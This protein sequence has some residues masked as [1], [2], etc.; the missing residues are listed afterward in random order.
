[1]PA[2][3]ADALQKKQEGRRDRKR[4]VAAKKLLKKPVVLAAVA[5]VVTRCKDEAERTQVAPLR[6]QLEAVTRRSNKH[7]LEKKTFMAAAKRA[8][9]RTLEVEAEKETLVN[10]V[11]ELRKEKYTLETEHTA[12]RREN[13]AERLKNRWYRVKASRKEVTRWEKLRSSPPRRCGYFTQ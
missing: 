13:D 9:A 11:E 7:M 3:S 1:M 10:T 6:K 5:H 12:L 2:T 8:E 4:A